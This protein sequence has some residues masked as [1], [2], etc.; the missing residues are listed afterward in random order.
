M[1]RV[2]LEFRILGSF[3]VCGEDGSA[4]ALGGR[5]RRALLAVLLLHRNQLVASDRLLEEVW[6]GSEPQQASASLQVYVS[7]LRKLL[8]GAEALQTRPGGYSLAVRDE[9]LDAAR[10]EGLLAEARQVLAEGGAERAAGQLRRALALWRGPPLADLGYE[11]FAQGEIARLEEL[12]L[13]ALELRLDAELALGH[14]GDLIGEL[15]TL[16]AE[17]PLRERLRGQLMLALYR[18]GR[19]ADAL[20][21]FQAARRT[22]LEELGLEPS[23]ELRQLEAAILRQDASLTVESAELRARRHLPAPATALVGREKELVEIVALLRENAP[24][25]VTL[26]GPGGTGKTRLGLQAA[27]ETVDVFPDGVFFVG[28]APL[29]DPELVAATIGQALALQPTG[30]Q[31]ALE[32]IKSQIRDKRLLLLLDNFEHVDEAAPVVSELLAEASGLNVLVTSRTA[33]HLYGE[34]EFPVPPLLQAE[35]VELFAARARAVDPQFDLGRSAPQ[36]VALCQSLDCLPLAIELAAARSGELSPAEMLGVLPRRL[37]LATHGARD[38]PARQQT[39]RATIEWS[40]GLLEESEQGLFGRLA[41]FVGG[42]TLDAAQSVCEADSVELASLVEKSLV[43]EPPQVDG[44]PR[45]A[46]LA[47][48][49]EHALERFESS[50]GA[51]GVLSRHGAYFLALAE[52]TQ[53]ELDAGEMASS[54]V[55]LELEHDNLRAALA[56]FARRGDAELQLRLGIALKNFW[57]VRGHF[58]EGRRVLAE[59]LAH[60]AGAPSQLRADA[61]T[62][63]GT[64]AYRQGALEAAKAAWEESLE[65]YRELDDRTGVARSVGELGSVAVGERDFERAAALYEES[66]AL[67]RAAGDTMRLA[68]VVANQGAIANMQGDYVRGR[69]LCEEALGLHR[70]VG[71]KDDVALTLQNLGRVALHEE[72]LQD[73]AEQLRES[74]ELSRELSYK[75][76]IAHGLEALAEL[77]AARAD[78]QRAARLVGAAEGLFEELGVVLQEDDRDTY[79]RTVATLEAQLGPEAFEAARSAGAAVELERAIAEALETL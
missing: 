70:E 68:S 4:L 71:A 18:S 48:V 58:D 46:M 29:G 23:P 10:F 76:M 24:R 43:L 74:L 37:E 45:F 13:L 22:L 59:A 41:V 42:W 30:E 61:L 49:R 3:E 66:A 39:L 15:E 21:A 16:V 40:H 6:G 57:W 14:H 35:A 31:T 44:E 26:S 77:A 65:L 67:F 53:A 17:Q 34:H 33:L 55:R 79:E 75:E 11:S 52:E 72:R 1:R 54:L 2:S 50:G 51:E 47:T 38:L 36:V 78:S 28:L 25:L 32:G 9:Q 73:A 20:A 62:A 60:G 69:Q 56:L 7:Q 5:K 63:L 8:G 12:R 64:L 27:A 19:Q